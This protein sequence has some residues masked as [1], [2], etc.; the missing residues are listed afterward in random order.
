MTC[1]KCGTDGCC[2]TCWG[3][4]G[5]TGRPLDPDD[6]PNSDERPDFD[7]EREERI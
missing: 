2:W 5:Y 6:N 3:E 1:Q 7:Y 4:D